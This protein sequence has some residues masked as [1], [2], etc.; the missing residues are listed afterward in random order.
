[1]ETG[2]QQRPDDPDRREA[3]AVR[4][5]ASEHTPGPSGYDAEL[6]RH[7]EVLRRAFGVQLHDHVLDIGCGT[8]QTTRQ[9]ARAARAGSALGVDVS[10]LREAG[11]VP[12][13]F[14][15]AAQAASRGAIAALAEALQPGATDHQV[16]ALAEQ[17]YVAQGGLHQIHYLGITAMDDPALGYRLSGRP[18]A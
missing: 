11:A 6:R 7:N 1:M 17:A 3:V 16:L 18:D 4:R 10:A 13:E 8:G 5:T 9:A 12:G 14:V 15:E 2:D